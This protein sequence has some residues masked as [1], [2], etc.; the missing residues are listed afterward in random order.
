[1]NRNFGL[2]LVDTTNTASAAEPASL[3]LT[4]LYASRIQ[5][6]YASG[7]HEVLV[8]AINESMYTNPTAFSKCS[9]PDPAWKILT[10]S[11]A[12]CRRVWLR[13]GLNRNVFVK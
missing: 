10:S 8:E 13:T 4:L 7:V 9:L 6:M 11:L 12:Q 3:A 5:E 1:M 2:D